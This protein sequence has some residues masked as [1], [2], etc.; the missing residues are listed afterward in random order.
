MTTVVAQDVKCP[1]CGE[2]VTRNVKVW[3][4]ERTGAIRC[5]PR[6]TTEGCHETAVVKFG[7]HGVLPS[8]G[9]GFVRKGWACESHRVKGGI[10]WT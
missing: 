2:A 3:Q 9:T 1:D 5:H 10:E 4:H 7:F 8:G 6:C